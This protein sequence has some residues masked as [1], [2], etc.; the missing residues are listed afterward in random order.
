MVALGTQVYVADQ[1]VAV[2]PNPVGNDIH[3]QKPTDVTVVNSILFNNIGQKVLESTSLDFS[4]TTLSTGVYYLEM[5]T[6][7][8]IYH[9][10]II[11]K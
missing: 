11:K 6:S 7:H 5:D 8:G 1:L 10:K 3:I 2:Y 9:K 4:A